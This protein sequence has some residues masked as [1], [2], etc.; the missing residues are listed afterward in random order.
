MKKGKEQRQ[1]SNSSS[2][3]AWLA[4]E[5]G[6]I[7]SSLF[8]TWLAVETGVITSSLFVT[9]L[10]VETGVNQLYHVCTSASRRDRHMSFNPSTFVT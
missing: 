1:L 2:S 6:V 10:A 5:T 7:T 4:I 9:W 8:V 3:A